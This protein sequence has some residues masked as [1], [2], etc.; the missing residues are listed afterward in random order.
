MRERWK[1]K[2]KLKAVIQIDR[3][4][5]ILSIGFVSINFVGDLKSVNIKPD[6][7]EL[8][9]MCSCVRAHNESGQSNFEER[10]G[11][12]LFKLSHAFEHTSTCYTFTQLRSSSS[13]FTSN[14]SIS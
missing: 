9:R 10:L 4:P 3:S 6:L 1:L 12:T 8:L 14:S 7:M 5:L 2:G 13:S 11:K